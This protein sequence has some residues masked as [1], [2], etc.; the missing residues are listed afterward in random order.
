MNTLQ[1]IAI[2]A[3]KQGSDNY[4]ETVIKA[5]DTT[6]YHPHI[7]GT[8][9][10]GTPN[11]QT[12]KVYTKTVLLVEP[13]GHNCT[14]GIGFY[15]SNGLMSVCS[16]HFVFKDLPVTPEIQAELDLAVESKFGL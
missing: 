3:F 1:N 5:V 11:N 16:G 12:H 15:V 9:Y 7:E 10:Y 6:E 2:E 4:G 8:V 14:S 13:G